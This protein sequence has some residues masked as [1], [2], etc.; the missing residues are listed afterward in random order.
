MY[1]RQLF[2]DFALHADDDLAFKDD[3][4]RHMILN[5]QELRQALELSLK[6]SDISYFQKACHKVNTTIR[7]LADEEFKNVVDGIKGGNDNPDMVSQFNNIYSQLVQS[8]EAER[9]S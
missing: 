5:L 2:V 6:H 3:L 4:I 7:L 9:Q 1:T 8:L